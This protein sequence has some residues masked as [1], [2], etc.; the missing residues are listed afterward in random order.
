MGFLEEE[1]KVF[2]SSVVATV[3]RVIK[4]ADFG[5]PLFIFGEFSFA[6]GDEPSLF[7]S[8]LFKYA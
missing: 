5:P 2:L 6:E 4:E 1:K 7:P 3:F 8:I